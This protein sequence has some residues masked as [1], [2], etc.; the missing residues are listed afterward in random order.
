MNIPTTYPREPVSV[1][2]AGPHRQPLFVLVGCK[3]GYHCPQIETRVETEGDEFPLAGE[4]FFDPEL[5]LN[6]SLP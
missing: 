1:G 5:D 6:T 3:R 2:S 4:S